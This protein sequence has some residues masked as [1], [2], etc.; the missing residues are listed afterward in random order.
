MKTKP[1]LKMCSQCV[2]AKLCVGELRRKEALMCYRI[3][4][5]EMLNEQKRI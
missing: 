1:K 4:K 3:Y 5:E 2:R